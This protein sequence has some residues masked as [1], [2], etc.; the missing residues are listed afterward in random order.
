MSEAD[1]QGSTLY[2]YAAVWDTPWNPQL[3]Q[4]HGY[5][6]TIR[7]GAFRLALE[8]VK[9][10]AADVPLL[11]GHDR[12][13]VLATTRA[14][15]LKLAED[16]KGLRVEA[17]LPNT[18]LGR[19][20]REMIARGDVAGMSFGFF[21]E[22]QDSNL[23]KRNGIVHR[24]IQLIRR[25]VD[26]TLTWEPAYPSTS[27]EVRTASLAVP[28]EELEDAGGLIREQRHGGVIDGLKRSPGQ[29]TPEE[30][31]RRYQRMLL[32]IAALEAGATSLDELPSLD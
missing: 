4:L 15:T 28:L 7:R 11:W 13:Q 10:G 29:M 20:V 2:G 1:I 27:L 21:S 12:N 30:Q 22:P 31:E 18:Q 19:D 32:R 8:A 6:E 9:Q 3:T 5:Q 23:S 25:L 14:G 17:Q 24:A 26:V 16:G